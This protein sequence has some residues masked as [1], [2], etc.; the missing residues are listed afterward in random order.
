MKQVTLFI[1]LKR[2]FIFWLPTLF[3][4]AII[5]GLSN[6]PFLRT[7]LQ[8][9]FILRKAAHVAEYFIL[10]FLLY[11]AFKR[12]FRISGVRLFT[13]PG[14]IAF[15]YT[16]TDEFHQLFVAGR[17]GCL[18]D[19]VIDCAG[20]AAFV[21]LAIVLFKNNPQPGPKQVSAC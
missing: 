21:T 6:I 5:F 4:A 15:L 14:G 19:I 9:D 20:I 18:K 11:R 16:L 13:F 2:T 10:T 3:W 8:A 12:S 1:K 17:V 7:N